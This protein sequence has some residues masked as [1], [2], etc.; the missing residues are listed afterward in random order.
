M[1]MYDL[2]L[3]S[4]DNVAEYGKE[5]K[6]G[7]KSCLAV[8]NEKGDV[9]DLQSIGE[10]TNSGSTLVCMSDDDHFVSTINQF[11]KMVKTHSQ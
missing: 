11:L 8:D 2:D 9:K 5:R 6:D 3:L 7:W 4:D 1:T 10:I